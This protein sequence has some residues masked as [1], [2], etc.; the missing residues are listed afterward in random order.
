MCFRIGFIGSG[1]LICGCLFLFFR[2]VVFSSVGVFLLESTW[3]FFWVVGGLPSSHAVFC[4]FVLRWFVGV[5][6][7]WYV[8]SLGV[9]ASLL[10][11]LCRS[12]YVLVGLFVVV[13]VLGRC[14]V[15]RVKLGCLLL[16]L[17]YS[18]SFE[19]VYLWGGYSLRGCDIS[20][21]NEV[22]LALCPSRKD[23]AVS[24]FISVSLY[25]FPRSCCRLLLL[26]LYVS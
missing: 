3:C 22:S 19:D 4:C 21:G 5:C 17:S 2:L 9:E 20:L 12:G 13:S 15:S 14:C 18:L 11:L 8:L 16:D 24:A 1:V 26:S 25:V 10:L 23:F 6:S 7:L